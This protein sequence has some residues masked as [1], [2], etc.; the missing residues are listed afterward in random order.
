[1]LANQ[2]WVPTAV[3]N[4]SDGWKRWLWRLR[5][6]LPDESE[7][8]SCEDCFDVAFFLQEKYRSDPPAH[9]TVALQRGGHSPLADELELRHERRRGMER[10]L[11]AVG[12]KDESRAPRPVPH[13]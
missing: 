2:P 10:L 3:R 6:G 12:R 1:M 7:D 5:L 11:Q 13:A 8:F 9:L 4:N